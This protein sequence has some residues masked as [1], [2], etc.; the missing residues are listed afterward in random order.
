MLILFWV[1]FVLVYKG[2]TNLGLRLSWNQ[3]FL[4]VG[5]EFLFFIF[6]C[7]DYCS[8][9]TGDVASDFIWHYLFLYPRGVLPLTGLIALN[10]RVFQIDKVSYL[11]FPMALIVD[12]L[13]LFI[14][15][16]VVTYFKRK[17]IHN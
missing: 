3:I 17:D 16:I 5:I 10:D 8:W 12:Y 15:S 6:F 7:V 2:R 11:T 1:Y 13:V 14:S 4:L 9:K